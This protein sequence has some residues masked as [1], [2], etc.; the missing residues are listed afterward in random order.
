M[1]VYRATI[2]KPKSKKLL[3]I[4]SSH[5]PQLC[6]P[7]NSQHLAKGESLQEERNRVSREGNFP[8]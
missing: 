3:Q 2:Q 5:P 1:D 6:I 7:H 4:E 8:P